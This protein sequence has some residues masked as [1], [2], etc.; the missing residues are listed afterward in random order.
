MHSVLLLLLLLRKNGKKGK[1]ILQIPG[2]FHDVNKNNSVRLSVDNGNSFF[3]EN[4][5]VASARIRYTVAEFFG[6]KTK[7][8][9]IISMRATVY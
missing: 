6:S 1:V 9:K 5:Q 2:D 3:S 7:R 4:A 8:F